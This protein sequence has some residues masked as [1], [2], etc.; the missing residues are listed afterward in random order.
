MANICLRRNA[1]INATTAM[2]IAEMKRRKKKIAAMERIVGT[3]PATTTTEAW[4]KNAV[5]MMTAIADVT[6]AKTRTC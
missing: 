6:K 2:A 5:A 3:A 4:T 1:A